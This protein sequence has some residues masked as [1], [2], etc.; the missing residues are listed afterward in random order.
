[1]ALRMPMP[2]RWTRRRFVT[3]AAAAAAAGAA[4]GDD[5]QA[6]W[7]LVEGGRALLQLRPRTLQ[8]QQRVVLPQRWTALL[9][10]GA[11]PLGR[12]ADGTLRRAGHGATTPVATG[13][14]ASSADGRWVCAVEGGHL[15]L[16]DADLA[17]LRRWALPGP[18]DGLAHLPLRRAF[19]L[20]FATRAELWQLST[21]EHAEDFYDGLVHDY[22]FGEGVPTRAFLNVRRMPLPEPLLDASADATQS[23]LAGRGWV[24]NLD[25]R[26]RVRPQPLLQPPAPGCA[27]PCRVAGRPALAVPVR[28]QPRLDLFGCDDWERAAQIALPRPADAVLAHPDQPLLALRCG[29]GLLLLDPAGGPTRAVPGLGHWRGPARWSADGR[30]LWVLTDDA[31]CAVDC[32]GAQPLQALPLEGPVGLA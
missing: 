14:V 27:A 6:L 7:V 20:A 19:V 8:L 22:R 2:D 10:G 16:R 17:P 4:R 21:D 28:A 15:Q 32:G 18:V 11:Q 30:V 29:T 5:G 9:A 25:A 12:G 26:K 31:L 23:E 24:F 1:M 3:A 13:P